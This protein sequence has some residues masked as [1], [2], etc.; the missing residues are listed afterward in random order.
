MNEVAWFWVLTKK[1]VLFYYVHRLLHHKAIYAYIHKKH[2]KFTAPLALAAQYAHP[3][4]HILANVIPISL[5]PRI[6]GCHIVT[7]W[8]F[9]AIEL[10]ETTLVHSGYDFLLRAAQSHDSHHQK[11]VGNFGAIGLLDWWH[12]T[13]L[14]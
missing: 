8:V 13:Q 7:F 9:L 3:V 6:L 10:L 5:P 2:H 4:E 14:N 11:F 1:Q 12:N